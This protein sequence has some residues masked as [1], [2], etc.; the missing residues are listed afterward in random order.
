MLYALTNATIYTSAQAGTIEG[1]TLLVKDGRIAAV[2]KGVQIPAEAK[3]I[4][5]AGKHITPGFVEAHSHLVAHDW[6]DQAESGGGGSALGDAVTPDID[7]YWNFD[8]THR[9]LTHA[10]RAGVTAASIRPG[11]GKVINGT[12]IVTK[13]YGKSR[14]E[15]LMR[16]N[17]GLK[18]AFGENPKRA[19]GSRGKMPSTRMGTAYLLR[20]ALLKAKAYMEKQEAAANDPE[21]KAPPYDPKLE[22][23]VALLKREIPARI[24]AHRHDDMMTAMRIADEF[25]YRMSIEHATT[26][27]KI[28]EEIAKRNIPCVVGPTFGTRGKV[29]VVDRT[30]ETPAVLEK[31]GIKVCITTDASV[32]AIDFLRLCASLALRAGMSSE[33]ALR[34]ITI[35]PAEVL[36]IDDRV[37][38]LEVGKDADF[39][40]MSGFPLEFTSVVEQTYVNGELAY[41]RASFKE[42]WEK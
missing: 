3:V 6:S 7:Y 29:E 26:G 27:H 42:D 37:G 14:K 38:S 9:H 36:S 39:L 5:M 22:P 4:D 19:F 20:D 16:R 31:A 32:I 18:M 35:N 11:S 41:D 1:A 24:H 23:I 10:L 30:F 40:V 13:M 34:A 28:V 17:D 8:P 33:G 2:G 15:L 12:G 25:G 21:K